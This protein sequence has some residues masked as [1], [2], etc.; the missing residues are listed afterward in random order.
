MSE[1]LAL[2]HQAIV[3]SYLAERPAEAARALQSHGPGDVGEVL[4][5]CLPDS[6]ARTIGNSDPD[7][8][9]DILAQLGDPQVDDI[10]GRMDLVKSAA[11]LARMG[12]ELREEC[13]TRQNPSRRHELVEMLSHPENSAGALMDPRAPLFPVDATVAEALRQLRGSGRRAASVIF[14]VDNDHRLIGA[15]PL[16]DMALA[17]PEARLSSLAIKEPISVPSTAMRDEVVSLLETTRVQTLPVVDFDGR[18]LGAIYH[19]SLVHAAQQAAAEDLQAMVGAGRS[20]RALS[21]ASLAV[22]NRLPWLQV[23]LATAFLAAAVVGV[24][25][26]TIARFT[27]LAVLL[28]VVAGQSGNTGAQA[29]AVTM[30]GLALREIRTNSWLRVLRKELGAAFVNGCAVAVT[31]SSVVYLWHGSPG[32][33][34]VLAVSMVVSMVMAGL[35]GATIPILLTK[36]GQDPAQSASIILTTVTDVVGFLSFL[37]FATLAANVLN[38]AL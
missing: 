33:P 7:L 17:D 10:L 30:R 15:I 38:I 22:R 35:A 20:E 28:P 11:I 1:G 19:D 16:Q 2:A 14:A 34:V 21:P 32:I 6:A 27:A 36:L 37:G 29:L 9:I 12:D 26:D 4:A 25:E 31:T 3:N 18:L 13:L 24:F 23:N 8:A 5:A